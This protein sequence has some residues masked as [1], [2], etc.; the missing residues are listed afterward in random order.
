[1]YFN[2]R[3]SLYLRVWEMPGAPSRVAGPAVVAPGAYIRDR[4]YCNQ[5]GC[6]REYRFKGDRDRHVKTYHFGERRFECLRCPS[7]FARTS[8]LKKHLET[9]Q[10]KDEKDKKDAYEVADTL[11]EMSKGQLSSESSSRQ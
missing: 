4:W 7:R 2:L 1:M 6:N 8:I 11:I 5:Y 9:H 10:K 3:A